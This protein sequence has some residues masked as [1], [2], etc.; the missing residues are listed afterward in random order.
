MVNGMM[1]L[2]P[3]FLGLG[4]ALKLIGSKEVKFLLE[5]YLS[6]L[7]DLNRASRFLNLSVTRKFVNPSLVNSIER[8]IE[9][10]VEYL[11]QAF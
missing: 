11:G 6:L 7:N 3:E 1:G 5:V 8:S 2:P 4:G 9:K 10:R